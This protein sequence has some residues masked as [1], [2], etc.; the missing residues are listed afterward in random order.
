MIDSH[1]DLRFLDKYSPL[2]RQKF[3]EAEDLSSIYPDSSLAVFRLFGELLLA[4]IA[5]QHKQ[6]GHREGSFKGESM[7]HFTRRLERGGYL[8][9]DKAKIFDDIRQ[10]GNGAVH[11]SSSAEIQL[12]RQVQEKIRSLAFWFEAKAT[13]LPLDEAVEHSLGVVVHSIKGL[14]HFMLLMKIDGRWEFPAMKTPFDASGPSAGVRYLADLLQTSDF[15]MLGP[16]GAVT[17]MKPEFGSSVEMSMFDAEVL[18]ESDIRPILLCFQTGGSARDREYEATLRR[19]IML[20]GGQIKVKFLDFD[21]GKSV[22]QSLGI[23]SAPALALIKGGASLSVKE[24]IR[25]SSEIIA[26]LNSHGLIEHPSPLPSKIRTTYYVAHTE[27]LDVERIG[28]NAA[29]LVRW[30]GYKQMLDIQLADHSV[31]PSVEAVR[32]L[33]EEMRQAVAV[34]RNMY[35]PT[36][37]RRARSAR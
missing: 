26:L 8:P 19:I 25:P 34:G 22:A 32:Y 16:L 14:D 5:K 23:S 20:R 37:F 36:W 11:L 12:A 24:G 15:S 31:E 2:L 28:E 35:D 21:D 27:Y 3:R 9:A 7:Y 18:R 33:L 30:V 17:H 1:W 6:P 29:S 13:D 4:E 10:I